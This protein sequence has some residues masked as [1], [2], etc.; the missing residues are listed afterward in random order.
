VAALAARGAWCLCPTALA[1]PGHPSARVPSQAVWG[2]QRV[3]SVPGDTSKHAGG[4]LQELEWEKCFWQ[5]AQQSGCFP[6]GGW[7]GGS[8]QGVG[9]WPRGSRGCRRWGFLGNGGPHAM[10]LRQAQSHGGAQ[11]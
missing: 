8:G 1:E 7:F 5:P 3:A 10:R 11:M 6:G 4:Q 2:S 9:G